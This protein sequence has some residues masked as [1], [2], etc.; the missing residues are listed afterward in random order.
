MVSKTNPSNYR[1]KSLPPLSSKAFQRIV[2]YQT[3]D[4]LGLH[5]ILYDY[6][7]GSRKN[8]STKTRLY[9]LNDKG[10]KGFDD[11]LLTGI[12]MILVDFQK[13]FYIIKHEK[14]L[15]Y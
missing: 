9:F 4:F 7:F 14:W 5:K 12:C 13:A 15:K 1:P 8:H 6:Q 10:L 2:L 11:G 3:N